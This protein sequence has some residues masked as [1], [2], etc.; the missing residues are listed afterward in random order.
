[1]TDRFTLDAANAG[2]AEPAGNVHWM[3]PRAVN[4]LFTGRAE[5][6]DQ[7]QDA[8]LGDKT[9]CAGKQRRF[10]I[11]GL[12]GQGKSEICLKV[13]NVMREEFWGVFWVDIGSPSIAESGFIAVARILGAT[14]ERIDDAL[15]ILA[16]E[17]RSWL[18]IL[19]N[20]DDPDFDYQPYLPS[21]THGAVIITSRVSRCSRYNTAG[22]EALAGLDV[23]H[24][25]RLLLKAAEIPEE[26]WPSYDQQ[27]KIVVSLLGSH[28]LALVQAGAYIGNGHGRLNQY[29][30][31]YHR[32]RQRLLKYRPS[33]AQSRYRDV[34]ATFEASAYMLERSESQAAKD[35]LRLLEILSMLHSSILPL[36]IFQDAWEGSRRILLANHTNTSEL[37]NLRQWH[38]SQLPD[39]MVIEGSEWDA[40]R[41]VEASSLLVSLSLITR[42][43]SDGVPGLSMHP[44]THAWAKDRQELNQQGQAWIAAASILTLSIFVS[45]TWQRQERHLRPHIQSCLT[46]EVKTAFSL[47]PVAMVLPIFLR[48]GRILSH[49]RDDSRLSRLLKEIF[50]QL[51]IDPEIPS[52]EFLPIYDLSATSLMDLGYHKQ[53]LALLEHIVETEETALMEDHPDRLASQHELAVAYQE[54]GQ[55]KQAIILLEHVVKIRETTLVEDHPDRLTSQHELARA[56]QA[57]G[58]VKQAIALLEHV[59]KIRETT[60]VEDHPD[61]LTSQHELARAYQANGQVKQAIALLEHVVK[62]RETTLVEDHPNRLA[63]QHE[64]ARAYQANGQVKQAVALLE[65]VVKIHK[66][67]LVED[68]PN[69]LASQSYQANGQVKQAIALLEHVVKIRETT[70]VEDHPNR[71][72]SQ[73]ELARAYQANGQ[74]KQAVALLEHV[75]KIHKTTLVEDHP[76]RLASQCTLAKAYQV[77]RQ[78]KQ[79]IAL[80]EHV[81]KIR[82]TTLAEDHPN[83]LASQRL[84]ARAYQASG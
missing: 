38:I 82:E 65:H 36:E 6:L 60:L 39:F 5:L 81:V 73:H 27:A 30:E 44:L 83:R 78:V 41:L 1:M 18:L 69:R 56:Y 76:N 43:D 40:Y 35:A 54:N 55:V 20:A 79:A 28:T 84:L 33:Q 19:D 24:S 61:R 63:S 37:G 42:H 59:V 47:G 45:D 80:L 32:Q 71:L 52:E 23:H 53:A 21:G 46:I 15:R 75:V 29:P 22:S 66:T 67:T 49:M 13:A 77:N 7:I 58:Q 14:V 4:N 10:V 70:L 74:V 2:H 51:K 8:L 25:T 16:N 57:N 26:S 50:A 72:A 64:L 11:T 17:K 31:V 68:H 62:I 3:V 9:S 48:C 34:Y 12:G